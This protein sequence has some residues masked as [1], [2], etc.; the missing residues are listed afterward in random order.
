MLLVH[1]RADQRSLH[2]GSAPKSISWPLPTRRH[3]RAAP[4]RFPAVV[5]SRD[6]R[7]RH[8]HPRRSRSSTPRRKNRGF[9]QSRTTNRVDHLSS[10][11]PAARV[12]RSRFRERVPAGR[13]AFP[14][15]CVAIAAGRCRGTRARGAAPGRR[16]HLRE[17]DAAAP[18]PNADA[19]P[20]PHRPTH[21]HPHL[22]R[23]RHRHLHR[24]RPCVVVALSLPAAEIPAP[25]SNS[26]VA[27]VVN[28]Q[29]F[30]GREF[31]ASRGTG[32]R[33]WSAGRS[34]S[35]TAVGPR[36]GIACRSYRA[37]RPRA[38]VFRG[39][40]HCQ[41]RNQ[42]RRATASIA[43]SVDAVRGSRVAVHNS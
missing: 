22:Q 37:R 25:Q 23:H 5:S 13:W 29:W 11:P 20:H 30:S 24:H 12:Q 21:P 9:R 38:L 36:R 8:T 3:H 7:D 6:A 10:R 15:C 4:R 16:P 2:R 19:H 43:D 27:A 34:N 39:A 14:C 40:D 17:R 26:A 41:R 28:L 31:V 32:V 1:R 18:Q 33:Q 42:S 35:V